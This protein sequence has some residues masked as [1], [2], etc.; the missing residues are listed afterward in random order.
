MTVLESYGG[1]VPIQ[2]DFLT[3]KLKAMKVT[4]MEK[5]GE[6]EKNKS[7]AEVKEEHLICLILSGANNTH[8]GSL[9]DNLAYQIIWGNKN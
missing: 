6:I 3:E 2:P 8:F 9:K 1:C 4:E 7:K 5:P